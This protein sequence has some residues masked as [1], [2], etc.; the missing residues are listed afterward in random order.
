MH[1]AGM[2][3]SLKWSHSSPDSFEVETKPPPHASRAPGL[4]VPG[5]DSGAHV[6][7]YIWYI[8]F[9]NAQ[10]GVHVVRSK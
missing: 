4:P 1:I 7:K 9:H 8:R 2:A 5:T 6:W 3:G 10:N